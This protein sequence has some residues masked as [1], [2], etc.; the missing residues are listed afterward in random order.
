VEPAE[1]ANAAAVRATVEAAADEDGMTVEFA[2][3]A[4]AELENQLAIS[5]MIG[6]GLVGMTL[7]VAV[8]GV[9][10]TLMLSITERVRETGL[11]RA[12][13]L[14]RPGVRTMVALEAALSG[15]GAAVLGVVIGAVYGVLAA[16]ALE[17][18][19]ASAQLPVLQLVGLVVAVVVVAMLAAVVPAVRAGRVPPI[20]ALQEA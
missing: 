12:V 14:T 9:G 7:L 17:L 16:K 2:A 13:G 1:G 5:S 6:L 10:V 4:R 3:D 19:T 11:L 8:V 15:S 20:R 18:D